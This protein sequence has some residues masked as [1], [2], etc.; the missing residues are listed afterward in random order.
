MAKRFLA[1]ACA[2]VSARS[3]SC[4]SLA[5]LL[6]VPG[7]CRAEC[8]AG[9]QGPTVLAF[10]LDLDVWFWAFAAPACAVTG[11]AVPDLTS[12]G[13]P[14]WGGEVR[15]GGTGC[16][17]LLLGASL[18]AL[19]SGAGRAAGAT[20]GK[21][22]G[23][24]AVLSCGGAAPRGGQLGCPLDDQAP[25]G[26]DLFGFVMHP[27]AAPEP[28]RSWRSAPRG[29]ACVIVRG[30]WDCLA[31]RDGDGDGGDHCGGP[32]Q[33]PQP[34]LRHSAETLRSPSR[35]P[36]HELAAAASAECRRLTVRAR[37]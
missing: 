20:L 29:L 30:P 27:Y 34:R 23:W 28:P 7:G 12:P 31:D 10:D 37:G 16:L 2:L 36:G 4:S 14:R 32:C 25:A 18:L 17:R 24:P 5:W 11:G 15:N 6:P 22:A 13:V 1:P 26:H 33:R 3:G 8:G 35:V 21:V 19:A 9:G